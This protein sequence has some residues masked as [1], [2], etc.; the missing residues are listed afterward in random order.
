MPTTITAN[1]SSQAIYLRMNGGVVEYS[2]GSTP[3]PSWTSIPN[4]AAWPVTIINSNPGASRILNVKVTNDLTLNSGY[5]DISG[6]FIAGS[7]YVTFDGSANSIHIN[8]IT[9]YPGFIQNGIFRTKNA[10]EYSVVTNFNMVTDISGSSSLAS[11]GG[12]LCQNAFGCASNPGEGGLLGFE[13][14]NSSNTITITNNAGGLTGKNLA[15][16]N[17]ISVTNC[18]NSGYIGGG[19][20]GIIGNAG[21]QGATCFISMCTNTGVINGSDSGGIIGFFSGSNNGSLYI[22]NCYNSGNIIGDLSGGIASNNTGNFGTPGAGNVISFNN[23]YNSG[24]IAG[25]GSGGIVGARFGFDTASTTK[26]RIVSCYSTGNITGTN[27]GG[28]CGMN[29]GAN[30]N[31]DSGG[32]TPTIDISNCYTLGNISSTCGGIVGGYTITT[33]INNPQINIS[34]AYSSGSLVDANSGL[35]AISSIPYITLTSTNTYV[36]N[37]AWTDSSA[38]ASLV[39]GL[40]TGVGIANQGSIWTSYSAANTPYLLSSYWS[41]TGASQLYRPNSDT[42]ANNYNSPPGLYTSGTYSIGSAVETTTTSVVTSVRILSASPYY[43]YY[44]GTF[45]L[46]NINGG[47]G[48]PI[49][50]TINATTGVISFI[51]P[52]ACFLEGTKILCFENNEE[53]Y[54]PIESLRKGD[55]VKTIYNGYLPIHKIGTSPIYNPNNDDRISD[56]LYKC[57]KENYPALFED[58]YITGCH[59]ILVPRLTY[60]QGLITMA[61]LGKLYVT[62]KHCRLMAWVDEKSEPYTRE[63][64]YNIYHI[65]LENDDYY[66]NYGIYANGLLVESCSKRFLTEMSNM[67]L[68]GE[69]DT[70][71]TEDVPAEENIFHQMPR[72]VDIC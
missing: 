17:T 29:I 32:R 13:V 3:G 52:R 40:P 37:A 4:T 19:S 55:L 67:R 6:Y 62:D 65:A 23:C 12:W 36:A 28:I 7:T 69:E 18:T 33:N 31:T 27:A 50:S 22:T 2:V 54:R 60:E 46:T 56:R 34:S 11:S 53:V 26:L 59:S 39:T 20:A 21:T 41:L 47:R 44:G 72:L 51:V 8:S 49:S 15:E 35:I 58:L 16:F 48:R 42:T 14:S 66:M 10:Y 70:S 5:G 68:L 45:T 30:N 25:V 9:N 71:L 38:N 57:P 43:G 24:N 64:T 63:G 1:G 61:L